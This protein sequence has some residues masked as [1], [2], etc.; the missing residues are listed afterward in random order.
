MDNDFSYYDY[1][2]AVNS[3]QSPSPCH[4][5]DTRLQHYFARYL[6]KQAIAEFKYKYPET[7]AQDYYLY[8]L[9]C[10]GYVAILN[11]N[12]FG[13]IPQHCTL[14]GRDVFYRPSVARITNPMFDKT[15]ELR[16]GTECALI[17]L[18]PDYA[19]ILDIVNYYASW[20]AMLA[21]SGAMNAEN[22]KLA[23]V[24][25]CENQAGADSFKRM[26]DK[27][28]GGDPAVFADKKLFDK[29]GKP[30]WLMFNSDTAK[31]YLLDKILEDIRTVRCAF[32]TAIGIPNSNTE[33]KERMIVD[34]VNSNN[35]ET[36]AL[37]D[38]WLDTVKIGFK[39]AKDLFGIDLSMERRYKTDVKSAV[40][41]GGKNEQ[42]V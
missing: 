30:L 34:E 14:G 28:Q 4:V 31:N 15:Y 19:G 38:L 27:I 16:I 9:F 21:E 37:S 5:K 22:T 1:M 24:F 23:Y 40:N 6:L 7:W 12:K 20:L 33:K 18:Q 10:Y 42:T 2:N 17:K 11:T 41:G 32:L 39:D 36:K 8:S 35:A 3:M 13:V 26:F 29:D 25:A